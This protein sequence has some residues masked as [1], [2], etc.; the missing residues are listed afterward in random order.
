M[1]VSLVVFLVLGVS[2][3]VQLLDLDPRGEWWDLSKCSARRDGGVWCES[4][5][6]PWGALQL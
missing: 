3:C 6:R 5:E 2:G 4:K 1:R